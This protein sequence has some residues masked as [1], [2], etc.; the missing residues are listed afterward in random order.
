MSRAESNRLPSDVSDAD[1]HSESVPGATIFNLFRL[2][3]ISFG[4]FIAVCGSN[5]EKIIIIS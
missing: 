4:V 5:N 3:I 1:E 2:L